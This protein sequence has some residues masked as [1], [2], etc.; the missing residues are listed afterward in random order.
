MNLKSRILLADD[1][2]LVRRGFR[3]IVSQ[4]DD[5]EVVG[6]AGDGVE[7]LR[8]VGE[9]RPHIVVLDVAMPEMNGVEAAQRIHQ[10]HPG[11]RVLILSMHKDAIYV[12]ETLRAGARGYLL[13]DAVDT[14]LI[15]ALRAIASGNSYISPGV[16]NAVLSDYQQFVGNPLDL[17]TVREREVFHLLAEG[18]TAKEIAAR[19]DISV[20]T[21]DAHRSKIMK[22]LQL[23]SSAELVRFAMRQG[24]VE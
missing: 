19:L 13:K 10:D 9:C 15:T 11:V 21:V 5:F 8:M 23:G 12:R 24:L 3:L 2:A 20:Y 1:H 7:A 6:E 18:R 17:L 22:K 4:Y 14:E 16:S